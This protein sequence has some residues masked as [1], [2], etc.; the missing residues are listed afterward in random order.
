MNSA[1]NHDLHFGVTAAKA[2][3]QLIHDVGSE[4]HKPY[5][6]YTHAPYYERELDGRGVSGRDLGATALGKKKLDP[7]VIIRVVPMGRMI[8]AILSVCLFG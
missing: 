7:F 3:P 4:S 5:S 2:S 6:G 1:F 8:N